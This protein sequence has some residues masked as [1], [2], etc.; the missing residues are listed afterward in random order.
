M[1][2]GIPNKSRAAAVKKA[3]VVKM[4]PVRRAKRVDVVHTPDPGPVPAA[5]I[6]EAANQV[7]GPQHIIHFHINS[8]SDVKDS[9]VD[10]EVRIG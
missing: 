3:S 7:F 6:T 9:N 10:V 5:M 1:P 4:A 2:R 8:R